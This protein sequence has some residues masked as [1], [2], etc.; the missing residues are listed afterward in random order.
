[1]LQST[2]KYFIQRWIHQHGIVQNI[3]TFM[4]C[5]ITHD[6]VNDNTL[7]FY[8]DKRKPERYIT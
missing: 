1:M 3:N 8:K 7:V 6:N 2:S 5:F 4:V